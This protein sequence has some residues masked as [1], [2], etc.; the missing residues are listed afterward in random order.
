MFFTFASICELISRFFFFH[1]SVRWTLW[2]KVCGEA[3]RICGLE[4]ESR[5]QQQ[6]LIGWQPRPPA[7]VLIHAHEGRKTSPPHPPSPR[8]RCA[9]TG[10]TVI[11][12]DVLSV[13]LQIH[14]SLRSD[15][16][17]AAWKARRGDWHVW[18]L[19]GRDAA[20]CMLMH[21]HA[22]VCMY[23]VCVC[24]SSSLVCIVFHNTYICMYMYEAW[25][26]TCS[27]THTGFTAEKLN[28]V[29]KPEIVFW[30]LF[31]FSAALKKHLNVSTRFLL[32]QKRFCITRIISLVLSVS[33]WRGRGT[34]FPLK[35]KV[36]FHLI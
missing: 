23:S 21:H 14:K 22:Y 25:V 2:G 12:G 13:D 15:E 26:S 1:F 18:V 28:S 19:C 35:P 9:V 3:E 32:K 20:N 5:R 29:L 4:P 27:R 17:E 10:L 34:F 30:F 11:W 31:F 6:H 24:L 7:T 16:I 8:R 33:V 36:V